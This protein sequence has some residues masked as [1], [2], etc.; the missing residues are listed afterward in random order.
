VRPC[1]QKKK[2]KKKKKKCK[3]ASKQKKKKN[4]NN[5]TNK[6]LTTTK[7]T[8]N[9]LKFPVSLLPLVR[10]PTILELLATLKTQQPL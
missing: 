8:T 10:Q 3:Q 9:Q 6:N 1:L 5:K 4:Q 7:P 2:K